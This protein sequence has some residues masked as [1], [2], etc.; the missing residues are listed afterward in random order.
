[1][2]GVAMD[3]RAFCDRHR[4]MSEIDRLSRLCDSEM[5]QLHRLVF[6]SSGE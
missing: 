3:R 6:V 1:M 4:V 5:S 2:S